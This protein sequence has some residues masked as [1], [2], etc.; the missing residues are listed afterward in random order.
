VRAELKEL[1]DQL[2]LPVLLVTHDFQDAAVLADR[3]AVL[4]D[5]RL[6]QIGTPT[7]LIAAPADAF[8]ASF[9]GANLLSGR[10]RLGPDGLTQVTLD[11]GNILYSVDDA[12]GPVDVAV[13]PWDVSIAREPSHDSALNHL[14]GP[15][16]SLVPLGNRARVQVGGLVAEVT[17]ASVDR[18]ALKPGDLVVASFKAAATRLVAR[19]TDGRG[20]A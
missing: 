8:V 12:I 7:E 17:T 15:I 11:E 18:L 20:E 3:G 1:L 4:V 5:G 2:D 10:A 6:R 14:R 13:Y 16:S 19:T 9:T